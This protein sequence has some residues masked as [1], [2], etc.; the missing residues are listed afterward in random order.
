MAGPWD[1]NAPPSQPHDIRGGDTL[2]ETGGAAHYSYPEPGL[3]GHY[4]TYTV[5]ITNKWDSG[6]NSNTYRHTRSHIR[7]V[8]P[9]LLGSISPT[10]IRS[11][12]HTREQLLLQH[13]RM[14]DRI[15]LGHGT[16]LVKSQ[17]IT[18]QSSNHSQPDYLLNVDRRIYCIIETDNLNTKLGE[19]TTNRDNPQP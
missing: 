10:T 18:G 6:S 1:Y 4:N 13:M 12:L 15:P 11:Q 9:T 16:S 3:S 5:I 2:F 19:R 8:P 17:D 14:A 7:L